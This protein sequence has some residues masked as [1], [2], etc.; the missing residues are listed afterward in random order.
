VFIEKQ[1]YWQLRRYYNNKIP[2]FGYTI[3]FFSEK[4]EDNLVARV[5]EEL[6]ENDLLGGRKDS[7]SYKNRE[8]FFNECCFKYNNRILKGMTKKELFYNLLQECC[9]FN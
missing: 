9:K 6:K 2:D 3:E 4:G 1:E 7:C 8:N 5:F